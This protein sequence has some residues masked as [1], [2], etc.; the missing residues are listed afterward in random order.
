LI[1]EDTPILVAT[2][3]H[4]GS[5]AAIREGHARAA[6]RRVKLMVCH[7]LEAG[8]EIGLA[9]Y[10]L[11][12]SVQE[13]TGRERSEYEVI[14]AEGPPAEVICELATR[15]GA[16]LIV[17]GPGRERVLVGD[18]TG[19]VIRHAECA[20]LVARPPVDSQIVLACTDFSDGSFP[21]L[22]SGGQEADRLDGSLVAL[23]VVPVDTMIET[24]V[25]GMSMAMA[26]VVTEELRAEAEGRL[27]QVLHQ[28][29]IEGSVCAVGGEPG[30][31]ILRVAQA[32][33]AGLIVIGT[34]GR[35]GWRRFFVGSVAERVAHTAGSSV[36]IERLA[37]P[38]HS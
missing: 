3:L 21:A 17:V 31:Q 28:H 36:L 7:V 9:N 34:H 30:T 12:E 13:L 23:H 18:T 16:G 15:R 29:R 38:L 11:T 8:E 14:L 24:D 22:V 20:V 27:R 33:P 19:N 32:L 37:P 35:T 26:P 5:E 6:A 1:H 2:D 25:M 4:P 10:L